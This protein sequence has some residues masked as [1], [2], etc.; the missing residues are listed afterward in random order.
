VP[1]IAAMGKATVFTPQ[2]VGYQGT[3]L[4]W[5]QYVGYNLYTPQDRYGFAYD[6]DDMV[7]HVSNDIND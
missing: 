7:R 3:M 1:A 4:D 2:R 6:V 5:W